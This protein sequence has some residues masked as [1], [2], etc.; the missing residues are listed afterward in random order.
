MNID[1]KK[2]KKII[3]LINQSGVCEIEIKEGEESI[4]ICKH[5][6]PQNSIGQIQSMALSSPPFNSN[7]YQNYIHPLP[8]FP[9]IASPESTTE[10]F[11]LKS[12]MVGTFYRSSSPNAKAFVEIGDHVNIGD[13]LCII[14]AMK[15][16]NQ[17]EAEYAGTIK[18]ILVENGQPVEFGQALFTINPD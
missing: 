2:V 18:S 9:E 1:L 4:K 15:M 8:K 14:E 12:P 3:E 16:F 6:I 5:Q 7:T 11:N 13:A 17:I 10:K